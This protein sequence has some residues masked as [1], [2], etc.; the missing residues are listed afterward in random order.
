MPD[1]EI[2]ITARGG[3]YGPHGGTCGLA[4]DNLPGAE[5]VLANARHMRVSLDAAP[6]WAQIERRTARSL[7]PRRRNRR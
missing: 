5:I 4:S 6:D 2:G 7:S 1:N 3:G